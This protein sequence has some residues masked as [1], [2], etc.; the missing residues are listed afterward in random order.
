M[1][2][3]GFDCIKRKAM[4]QNRPSNKKQKLMSE[5]ILEESMEWDCDMDS[6]NC[7][8][9]NTSLQ[10]DGVE[11]K[12]QKMSLVSGEDELMEFT[13]CLDIA[14]NKKM[15]DR[16]LGAIVDVLATEFQKMSLVSGEDE[17]MD[18]TPSLDL[19]INNEMKDR[20]LGAI[21]D[22]LATEFQKMHLALSIEEE[23]KHM[24]LALVPVIWG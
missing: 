20:K 10:V 7:W 11:K 3:K 14:I 6:D 15:K 23:E 16:K 19:S 24:H 17:L 12:F 18:F 21:V 4:S 9:K 1:E 8:W 13:P 22:V 5:G 2:S